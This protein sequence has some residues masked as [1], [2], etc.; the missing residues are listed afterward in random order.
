MYNNEHKSSNY[1]QINPLGKV[2]ALVDGDLCVWDSHAICIYLVEKY[3]KDDTLYPRDLIKRT[4][5]NQLL[6]F[7]GT[8]LFQKMY[9]IMVPMYFGKVREIPQEKINDMNLAYEIIE[10]FLKMDN[11]F[12]I[13]NDLTIADLSVWS[14]LLSVRFLVPID[15]HKYPKLERWLRR[16]KTRDTYD[17]NQN[18]ANQH[19]GEIELFN[20]IIK[21]LNFF[22]RFHK[23]VSRW[24]TNNSSAKR[25]SKIKFCS[26]DCYHF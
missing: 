23:I 17:I 6:F 13:G 20:F 24:Q 2:P 22:I 19:Y 26:L 21:N 4:K 15:D 16:M 12:L 8:F 5:I 25:I 14:T 9:E 3:A 11:K 18:G 10:G 7:E 1:N